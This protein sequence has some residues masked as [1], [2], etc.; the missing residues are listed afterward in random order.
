MSIKTHILQ[1]Q[2]EKISKIPKLDER[3]KRL[4]KRLD[5]F[6]KCMVEDLNKIIHILDEKEQ[7][8]IVKPGDRFSDNENC[9][10]ILQ[11]GEHYLLANTDGG[12]VVESFNFKSSDNPDRVRLSDITHAWQ[13]LIKI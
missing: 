7:D 11:D 3:I 4:E 13:K 10:M 8:P 6:E 12:Y 9:F 2:E 1:S 5:L